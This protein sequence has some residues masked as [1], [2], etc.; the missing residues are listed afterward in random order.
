[1]LDGIDKRILD[2]LQAEVPLV[3]RPFAAVGEALRVTEEEVLE[4][5]ARMK[6]GEGGKRGVLRQISAIFDSKAL[7]YQ[8]TLVAARVAEARI[9]EAAAVINGHPGVSHNYRRN[10]A[11]NLWYTLAVP[12]DSRLGLERTVEILH[13]ESG[14]EATRML[15]TLRLFKIGVRFD[16][17]GE[18]EMEEKHIEFKRDNYAGVRGELTEGEKGMIRV[19]QRD[20]P[21]VAEPFAQWAREA[22]VSVEELLG[23]ARGFLEKGWMRRFA[24]VLRHREAGI[25]ANAMGVWAVPAERTEEFGLAAA[26][27]AAVSHCYLRRSWPDWPYTVFTMVHAATPEKC[28]GVLAEIAAKTGVREYAALYST[29]EYKKMR[30][31]YFT[32][33]AALWERRYL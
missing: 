8:T 3:A 6:A 11:F 18:G 7:G 5:V 14:A 23:A 9:E 19:L 17:S 1:M 21:A 20:L 32:A 25:M 15:P 31:Q 33:D 10:H 30:V 12:P 16:M 2:R 24:A 26:G 29:K 22:G 13:R 27:L 28:E 4:R